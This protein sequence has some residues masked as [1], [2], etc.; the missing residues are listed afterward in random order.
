EEITGVT[1]RLTEG[2]RETVTVTPP[3]SAVAN[4]AFDVTPARL[5]SGLVTERG[6]L[7]PEEA[8]LREAFAD[9]AG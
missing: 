1:G 9:L 3:N 6:I 4:Y 2:E 8:T 7:A 5:V